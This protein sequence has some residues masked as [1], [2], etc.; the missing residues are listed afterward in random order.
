MEVPIRLDLQ[1]REYT[2]QAVGCHEGD[3]TSGHWTAARVHQNEW[4]EFDDRH[5]VRISSL[6][7]WLQ[8]NAVKVCLLVYQQV[9]E[10][11]RTCSQSV[12]EI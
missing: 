6:P 7:T 4:H 9:T 12:A 11:C 3:V 1:G 10:E 5:V 2:L 8:D